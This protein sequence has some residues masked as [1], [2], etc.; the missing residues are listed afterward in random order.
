MTKT[1]ATRCARNWGEL[2][3]VLHYGMQQDKRTVLVTGGTVNVKQKANAVEG[4]GVRVREGGET[5][6]SWFGEL[7]SVLSTAKKK[8]APEPRC[9]RETKLAYLYRQHSLP[10]IHSTTMRQI[11]GSLAKTIKR[12]DKT[13]F[14]DPD[15]VSP[16]AR[17]RAQP[18]WAVQPYPS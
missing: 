6:S 5:F 18:E 2:R 15:R 9:K 11:H 8:K 4:D 16:R 14:T 7:Q 3:R 10:F 13:S 17:A 12:H 1:P